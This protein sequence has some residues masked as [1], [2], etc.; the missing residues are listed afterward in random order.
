MFGGWGATARRV[1][2]TLYTDA[3]V[4]RGA[5]E[6]SQRRVSDILNH[7]DTDFLVLVDATFESHDDPKLVHRA[8]YAQ[9]NLSAVL[10]AVAD[11]P[12]DSAPELR[13]PKNALAS[14]ISIP[15]FEVAGRVHLLPEHELRA[16]LAELTGRF[17][18]V[19]EAEFWSDRIGV[20]RTKA[21]MVAVNHARAQILSPFG[22]APGEAGVWAGSGS[23]A[24]TTEASAEDASEDERPAGA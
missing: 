1:D 4:I 9:V 5:A 19:T 24:E 15:P 17:L 10:F 11:A 14:L 18:P 8:T 7:S 13:T 12:A 3:Y 23:A 21:N 16:A 6:T 20:P 2:L 22:V